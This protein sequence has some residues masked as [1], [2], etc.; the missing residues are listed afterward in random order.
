MFGAVIFHIKHKRVNGIN[1]KMKRHSI[2][3]NDMIEMIIF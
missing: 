2:E 3:S 1:F